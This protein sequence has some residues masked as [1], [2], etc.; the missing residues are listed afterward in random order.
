MADLVV[1]GPEPMDCWRR[2]IPPAEVIRLGRAPRNGWAVPWDALISREHAELHL[3]GNGLRVKRLDAARNPIYFG[4]VETSE[5]VLAT[6]EQFRIGRT[7][8]QLIPSELE[9]DSPDPAEERSYNHEE[10][11]KFAFQDADL[12]LEVLTKLPKAISQTS[13]D[14]ELANSVV[15]LLLE[16][17]L[18]AEA[19]A[20]VHFEEL[21]ANARPKMM[22]W[23]S[24]SE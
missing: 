10:L 11:R 15:R 6:G 18:N 2:E 20:V 16:A 13:Q 17:I 12:R 24:R 21:S 19:A 22:R 1:C 4:D 7:V 8:F 23:D 5:F 9:E 14:E 3:E